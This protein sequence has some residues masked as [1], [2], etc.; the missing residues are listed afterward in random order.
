TAEMWHIF[1][2]NVPGDVVPGTLGRVV[3][4][5]EVKA[6]EDDGA[7]VAVGE[8][9]RLWVRGESLGLGYWQ[10]PEA[11]AEAFRGEW[12]AGGDLVSIDDEG[13]VT[14]RGRAD[15]AIKVKGKWFRPQELES[16]LLDHP[17]VRECAVVAIHDDSGLLRP[18]AF[19]V[20]EGVTEDELKQWALARLEPYKHPRSVVFLDDLPRTHLG[21]VDRGSLKSLT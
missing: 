19:V 6:A 12:F 16:V 21:K 14:H 9:G 7:P 4:G 15:D 20:A 2:S 13:L 8:V 18:V 10:N 5:F 17:S 3:P 1:V 11:T